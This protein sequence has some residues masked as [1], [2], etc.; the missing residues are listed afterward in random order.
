MKTY[1]ALVV[2]GILTESFGLC[3]C[4]GMCPFL[5]VSR[6]TNTAVGMDLVTGVRPL[7]R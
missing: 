4:L 6:K 7:P 1:I 3:R 5:G 2:M